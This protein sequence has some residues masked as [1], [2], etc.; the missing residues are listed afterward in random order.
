MT[1]P[2]GSATHQRLVSR[3]RHVG[4]I[5]VGDA[6]PDFTLAGTGGRD[7]TLAEE[8]G[9]AVVLA[10]Y[11]GDDTPV[12]TRQL[13][14]YNDDLAQ[15]AG[16][17]ARLFGI[18]PQDVASH[19]RFAAKRGLEM[20]LLADVDKKVAEAYGILGPLGFYRRSVFVIDAA[21]TVHFA[22]RS[23]VGATYVRSAELE[24][25]IRAAVGT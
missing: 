9:H 20:V 7:Y 13:V 8:R 10:F 23:I 11:P 24:A 21:G 19:E 6:A 12:C 15:F 3:L 22:H 16:L 5:R 18:S 17:G 25:A 1:S 4:M 2:P 14:S